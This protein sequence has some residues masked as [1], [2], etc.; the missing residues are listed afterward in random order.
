MTTLK[1]VSKACR[2][3]SDVYARYRVIDPA[4]SHHIVHLVLE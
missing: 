3:A 2:L 4:L 1:I